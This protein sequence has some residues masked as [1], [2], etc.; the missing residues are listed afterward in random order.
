[1]RIK[2]LKKSKPKKN[3]LGLALT[4][5]LLLILAV[6]LV[7][8]EETKSWN[9]D[10]FGMRSF[11]N[12]FSE[13]LGFAPV[14]EAL[15]YSHENAE[16]VCE[17]AGYASYRDMGCTSVYDGGRCGWFSPTNNLLSQWE[18]S[19]FTAYKASTVG[20]K[21]LTTLTCYNKIECS[22]NT[23]CGDTTYSNNFCSN[24]NVYRTVHQPTCNGIKCSETTYNELIETCNAGCNAGCNQGSCNIPSPACSDELDN[25]NDGLFDM[26]DPGCTSPSDDSEENPINIICNQD[27]DCN[28]LNDYTRDDCINPGCE[29]SHCSNTP[30]QCLTNSDCNDSNNY[31]FDRC[32][33]AGSIISYCYNAPIRC[34]INSDCNDDN[35]YTIDTCNNPGYASSS[36][37]NDEIRCILNSDCDDGLSTTQDT[38]NNPGTIISSCSNDEIT[39]SINSDCGTNSFIGQGFCKNNNVYKNYKTFDCSNPGTTNSE[40][41]SNTEE[42]KFTDCLYGCDDGECNPEPVE[43]QC[44]NNQDDDGDNLI[45]EQD[46]GC[47][48]DINDSSTYNPNLDDESSADIECCNNGECGTN[49][50][51]GDKYC[52]NEKVYQDFK[53]FICSNPGL[54]SSDCSSNIEQILI[55]NCLYGCDNSECK[56]EPVEPEDNEGSCASTGNCEAYPGRTGENNNDNPI[57]LNNQNSNTN[58]NSDYTQNSDYIIL[59]KENQKTNSG[60]SSVKN[61]KT[62]LMSIWIITLA[63]LIIITLIFIIIA[64]IG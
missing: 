32:I 44:E 21:W 15:L 17:L 12:S 62:N 57:S 47:W 27:S 54:G 25:D 34:L 30:I 51:I 4:L 40:C 3:F 59:D 18:G 41:N 20:N 61:N 50:F 22:I 11:V 13:D 48:D 26:D 14:Q 38:C 6:S 2:S 39:C 45:D 58:Q 42:R 5:F 55:N 8:A 33:N 24:G 9:K 64:L 31:T 7:S 60:N 28:D 37:S 10:P 36:C 53:E 19:G 49:G 29:N 23:D 16:K 46:P 56:E 43:T 1:M 35:M 52:L 63:I